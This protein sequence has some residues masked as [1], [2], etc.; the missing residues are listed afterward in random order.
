MIELSKTVSSKI[1]SFEELEIED[2]ELL[3]LALRARERAQAPYSHYF[4]GV[5]VKSESG[6]FYWG[7][8]VERASYSQTTHAEQNALDTMVAEEGPSKISKLALIG[9]P[10]G[11]M[12][13]L[14]P[15]RS[16]ARLTSV[17]QASVPCGHC[18]QII[19]ENCLNDRNVPIIS[20]CNNGEISITTI[21]SAFPI[22]FG[23]SDLG[24][25][26]KK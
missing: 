12:I 21:D 14:P 22:K 15:V 1:C 11:F 25:N 13:S 17:D 23:P 10:E 4:V 9:A 6:R 2:Q 20:L 19:W 5:A 7:C 8:N 26:I 16:G 18:L 3:E 24:V